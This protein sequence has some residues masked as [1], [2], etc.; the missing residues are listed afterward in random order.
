MAKMYTLDNK[1]LVGSPEIRI[2]E[3][4]FAVDNRK[5]TVMKVIKMHENGEEMKM[6]DLDKILELAFGKAKAKE[7]DDMDLSFAAYQQLSELVMKAM[8]GQDE[9]EDDR[10]RNGKE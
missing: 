4:V 9:D 1:L 2:G 6:D 7:I 10:F 5:K 8:T 3:K